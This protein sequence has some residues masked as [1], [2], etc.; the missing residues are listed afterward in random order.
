VLAWWSGNSKCVY[1]E[2]F[3]DLDRTLSDFNVTGMVANRR[4][5]RAVSDQGF[6]TAR[7]MLGYKTERNGGTLVVADR[8][9]PAARRAVTAGQ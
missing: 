1:Q 3:R 2:A 8:W 4:M 7:R 5:A 9:S 6:G